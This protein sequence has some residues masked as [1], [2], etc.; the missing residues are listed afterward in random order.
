MAAVR[1][2]IRDGPISVEVTIAIDLAND[3]WTM[4][5]GGNH[6]RISVDVNDAS[7]ITDFP[8][9]LDMI[10]VY[11]SSRDSS[12]FSSWMTPTILAAVAM[13]FNRTMHCNATAV[14]RDGD[15]VW[16]VSV[17]R[18]RALMEASPPHSTAA[19]DTADMSG[20][21]IFVMD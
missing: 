21:E 19:I 16:V 2:T 12:Y 8:Q 6:V 9:V 20:D 5:V 15:I 3:T 14:P 7:I 11:N 17:A 10:A 4:T 1:Y 18:Q 13:M